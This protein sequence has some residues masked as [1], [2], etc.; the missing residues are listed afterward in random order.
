MAQFCKEVHVKVRRQNL[1]IYLVSSSFFCSK[2][3]HISMQKG[4]QNIDKSLHDTV[5]RLNTGTAEE[6]ETISSSSPLLKTIRNSHER[7]QGKYKSN[8]TP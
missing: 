2:L 4:K 3:E 6:T 5:N 8:R 1:T 7:H